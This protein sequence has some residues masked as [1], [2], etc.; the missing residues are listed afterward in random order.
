MEFRLLGPVELWV[1]GRSVP[2]GGPR[3]RSVVAALA[4]DAG[5]SVPAE[6]LI[7]RVWGQAPPARARHALHVYIARLRGLLSQQSEPAS[8]AGV[9]HQAG[10]YLLAVAPECV[11]LH[12]FRRIVDQARDPGCLDPGRV[13]LLRRALDLWRGPP[14]AELPGEW[15]VRVRQGWQ[16][17][18]LDAVLGWAH[19]CLRLGDPQAVITRLTD[20]TAEHPMVESLAAAYM[21]ALYAAGRPSDAL[22]HFLTVQRVL[23]EELGTDP[24]PELRR[25]HRQVLTA[26]PGLAPPA[27]NPVRSPVPR[28]LPA[29]PPR[30]AGRTRELAELDYLHGSSR[31]VITVISGMA[32]V[33]K[34][35]LALHWAHRVAGR[36]PGGQLYV[37]L[38]GFDPGGTPTQPAAA[39]RGFLDGLG[40]PPERIPADPDAQAAL[41]RSLL[42]D[43]RVLV[44]LDNVR[45]ADQVRPLLPGSPGCLAV[46][47]SRSQLTGLV[48]T[49]GAHPL[50]LDLLSPGEARE[51]LADR[52]GRD[53]VAA[54][55][56]AVAEIITRC[57]RLPLALA[58]TAARA[59]THPHLALSA[60]AADLG[61]ARGGLDALDTGDPVAD[62]RAVFSWSYQRLGADA[63]RLFRLLGRHPGPDLSE[64]AAASLAG[65]P[66]R[67]VRPLL[68][69]L[70]RAHLLTEHAAGRYTLHDLLRAYASELTSSRDR[71]DDRD[72][73]LHR[74]LDHYLHT[75]YRAARVRHPLRW[76][77]VPE[78]P[79][80]GVAP[81]ELT[82]EKQAL[83]WLTSE[84]RVLLAAVRLAA[85]TGH[86][87]HACQLAWCL[88][89]FLDWRGHWHDW[90]ATQEVAI[91]AASRLGDPAAQA[92]AHRG[93]AGAHFRRGDYDSAYRHLRRVISLPLAPADRAEVHVNLAS[94]CARQGRHDQAL[95]HAR[96]ALA[97]HRA[98]GDRVG[99]GDALHAIGW[100][101]A[102][103]GDY[104]RAL[105]YGRQSLANAQELGNREGE[106]ATWDSLG[107]AYQSL[108]DYPQAVGCY[109]HALELCRALSNRYYEASGLVHLGDAQAAAGDLAAAR[110]VWRQAL[111]LLDELGHPEADQVRDKLR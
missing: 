13:A 29:P 88:T 42:A 107:Q 80:P 28:H 66:Q 50:I 9:V 65:V 69:E 61:S 17:R 72:A 10:G 52:L 70:T 104:R 71:D 87:R 11:D 18:Y 60:L 35:A 106:A 63:A 97:L 49:D 83:A 54:E 22:A 19:A 30:F 59:A 48:A 47:T 101:Y 105:R 90:A 26:D 102:L 82:D 21:R 31:A 94:V 89:D 46:A 64:P 39:I 74:L 96:Q 56:D 100:A 86:D 36:F 108:G 32:G 73:A 27:A 98:A 85:S 111:E 15:A 2:L 103:L 41:Y 92:L 7:D 44:V 23:A 91:Q 14:L 24:G 53:R 4:V 8:P 1:A 58:I 34:S 33:G 84:H 5:G 110:R 3:Q 55:P 45:D 40:V 109:Q 38:R 57:G 79:G 12:Q 20:L 99:E 67:L 75:A 95:D 68:V 43:Q 51:L 25:L 62:V 78:G 37:N 77:F 76:R 93:M 81:E 6:T 16:Q